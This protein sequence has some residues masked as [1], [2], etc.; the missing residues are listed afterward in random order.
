MNIL[1]LC[2]SPGKGGLELYIA[3]LA[4]NIQHT[5]HQLMFCIKQGTPLDDVLES[6]TGKK[7]YLRRRITYLPIIAATRLANIID[8]QSVDC[9]LINWAADLPLAAMARIFSK[10]KPKLV[11]SRHMKITRNKKDFYHRYIY[12]QVDLMLTIT[13]QVR[14]EALRYL[15]LQESKVKNCYLGVKKIEANQDGC[16]EWM[17]NT[18]FTKSSFRIAL[19]GRIEYYKGQHLLVEAVRLIRCQKIDVQAAIIGHVMDAEYYQQ[20]VQSI[21]EY[22]L[23][24]QIHI[25][26]FVDNPMA[27]MPC[28]DVVVLTTYE[29]T[30]G[31]V[32]AEAMRSGVAVVGTR[33]GGVREIIDDGVT[34]L[35]FEPGNADDLARALLYLVDNPVKR[36]NIALEG[37]KKADSLFDE[38]KH[39]I[40]LLEYITKLT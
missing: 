5:Q 40:D 10:T 3:N 27:I 21:N 34:G 1:V 31:L 19:F 26:D 7:N 29:E 16:Q 14:N 39:F 37:K 33:A 8:Q 9:I 11:Y 18:G 20:L 2:L 24:N 23:D 32:L 4:R 35:M 13:E 15:P 38:N 22:Q 12:R 28:F 6:R 17:R 36:K 30:F 25:L